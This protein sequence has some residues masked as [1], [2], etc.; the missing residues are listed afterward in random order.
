MKD[1]AWIPG[2]GRTAFVGEPLE[3]FGV[4]KAA[5]V[6]SLP[7]LAEAR[8]SGADTLFFAGRGAADLPLLEECLELSEE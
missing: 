7:G 3:A 8:S 1:I 5:G 2:A 4:L 6:S